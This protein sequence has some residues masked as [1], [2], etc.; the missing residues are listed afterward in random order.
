MTP[1]PPDFAP[2][3]G[4]FETLRVVDGVPLFVEEHAAEWKR[5][6]SMLGLNA[7]FDIARAR[8]ALLRQ[9]GRW[10]WIATTEGTRDTF[11]EEPAPS[12]EPLDLSIAVVRV[13]SHNWDARFKTLSY[14]THTQALKMASTP[15]AVLLNEH[16]EIA[17][18]ARANIFWRRG[19]R[20][21][22]PAH[23]TG[24]RRGVSPG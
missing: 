8:T 14:L 1:V 9:S 21:F 22:T 15:E 2:W 6:A 11:S 17:S 10:R 3:L 24:C 7:D 20:F 13:G 16:G 18:A 12:E 5:S 19:D 4:V 23:E